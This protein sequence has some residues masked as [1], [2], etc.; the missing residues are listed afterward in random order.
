MTKSKRYE[1]GLRY[2]K[3]KYRIESEGITFNFDCSYSAILG[4]NKLLQ[5]LDESG[6]LL[7][8]VLIYLNKEGIDISTDEKQKKAF[9]DLL[10]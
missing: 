3:L 10:I 6:D 9:N 2:L 1:L 5:F 4:A 8:D 7:F